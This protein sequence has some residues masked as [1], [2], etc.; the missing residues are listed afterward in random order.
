MHELASLYPE[1]NEEELRDAQE[2]ID[3]YLEVILCIYERHNSKVRTEN[4]GGPLTP[5]SNLVSLLV[6]AEQTAPDP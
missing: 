6:E 1:L 4:Q 5:R 2:R 3:A